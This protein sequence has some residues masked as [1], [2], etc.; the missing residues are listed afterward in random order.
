MTRLDVSERA[1]AAVQPAAPVTDGTGAERFVDDPDV[2]VPASWQPKTLLEADAEPTR[3]PDKL[4]GTIYGN[5]VGIVSGEPGV[6]KSMFSM[7]LAASE[8]MAKRRSLVVDLERT[9]GLLLERLRNAGLNDEQI[10]RID[11][12]RPSEPAAAEQVRG[13]MAATAVDLVV[14]DSYDAALALFGLETKTKTSSGSTASSSRRCERQAR[15]SFSSTTWRR[16]GKSAAS[17]RSA[18]SASSPAPTGTYAWT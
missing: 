12:V 3:R 5:S 15:P 6:G 18:A 16:T 11:Y 10:A 8:A 2:L 1:F 13:L 17:T 7:A 14:V 4:G 9:P